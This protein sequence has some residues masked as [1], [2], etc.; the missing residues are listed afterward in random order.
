MYN[1][2]NDLF[3]SNLSIPPPFSLKL[4]PITHQSSVIPIIYKNTTC[5]NDECI[6]DEYINDDLFSQLFKL[7]SIDSTKNKQ[8]KS[9][10][11]KSSNTTRKKHKNQKSKI[12]KSN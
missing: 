2:I 4:T 6:T 11:H 7:I 8:T 9:K 1:T 5:I 10:K 12:K 3:S